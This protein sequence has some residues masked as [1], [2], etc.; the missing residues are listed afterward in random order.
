VDDADKVNL[1]QLFENHEK[2]MKLSES[3]MSAD[4]AL[5]TPI[6]VPLVRRVY[7]ALVANE[8]VGIQSLNMPTGYLY[9]MTN[10]YTGNSINSIKPAANG[11]IVTA[12]SATGFVVGG[13]ITSDGGATGKVVYIEGNNILVDL[14]GTKLFQNGDHLDNAN[15]FVAASAPTTAV[16]TYSNQSMFKKI[17]PGYSGSYATSAGEALGNDMM[18]V[19]FDIERTMAE[20]KTRKLKA[21]YT[22]E[23]FQ[24]L[25]AMHGLDG[26]KELMD[27][28]AMELKLGIDREVVAK[29]ASTATVTVDANIGTYQGRWEVEKYRSLAIRLS[30]ESRI[31]GQET[32]KGGGNTML[33]SGKV[34]TAL[35]QLGGFILSPVKASMDTVMAGI[36]PAVGTFDGRYKVV[37]DNFATSDYATV[38]YKG[39]TNKDAGL[40]FAPY[41]MANVVKTV[42]PT[43]GQPAVILSSR[44]DIVANPMNPETYMRTMAVNFTGTVL[45]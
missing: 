10:R 36:T 7:P 37:V 45:A 1:A 11:Q 5:F 8:L 15:P 6:L 4:V 20:A 12:G 23:L 29:I 32:R 3:I 41:Q 14:T 16:S 43:S 44:Y 30:N 13:D 17:L 26:E 35:E 28:M 9:A 38:I 39:A 25:K 18:E 27:L 19:G 33:V 31:I 34:A 22:I 2:E 42:D 40:F 21:K 24:D